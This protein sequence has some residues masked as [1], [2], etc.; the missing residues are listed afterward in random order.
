[1]VDRLELIPANS[2]EFGQANIKC[3]DQNANFHFGLSFDNGVILQWI[4]CTGD[5]SWYYRLISSRDRRERW[6]KRSPF[7]RVATVHNWVRSQKTCLFHLFAFQLDASPICCVQNKTL[8]SYIT[9]IVVQSIRLSRACVE[10]SWLQ[11]NHRAQAHPPNF[12]CLEIT[13]WIHMLH[14]KFLNIGTV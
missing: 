3:W 12:F 1:V 8:N 9:G 10:H 6:P 13:W 2:G 4:D 11:M 14:L 7:L 5:Q